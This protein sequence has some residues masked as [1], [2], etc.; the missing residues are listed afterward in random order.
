MNVDEEKL[1]I[2]EEV[3]RLIGNPVNSLVITAV[4]ESL[5]YRESDIRLKFSS[6]SLFSFAEEI[7]PLCTQINKE[8]IHKR[9]EDPT[10][11]KIHKFLKKIRKDLYEL[12]LILPLLG[13]IAAIILLR[14]SLWVYLDFTETE[15]TIVIIGLILSF[16]F[17]GGFVQ[18]LSREIVFYF[19]QANFEIMSKAIYIIYKIAII[20]SVLIGIL[21]LS[22]NLL[23]SFYPIDLFFISIL[24]FFA[25]YLLWLN[26]AILTVIK[27]YVSLFIITIVGILPVHLVMVFSDWGI[28][29]AHLSGI[30]TSN[31]ILIAYIYFILRFKTKNISSEDS[32]KFF[33]NI[34]FQS[35]DCTDIL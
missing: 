5:G 33:R 26:M 1:K 24:Y 6:Y 20:F 27:H 14:Y 29:V 12:I 16:I 31:V 8:G 35:T 23:F 22:L 18:I 25:L 7:F 13:Q 34:L 11:S 32:E 15:A 2:A 9:K 3:V 28:Y 19:K 30:Q 21:F 4:L 17:A 10:V